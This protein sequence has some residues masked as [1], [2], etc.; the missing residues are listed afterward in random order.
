[1]AVTIDIGD[2]TDIHPRNKREVGRRLALLALAHTYGRTGFEWS[3]PR[4][5]A[6]VVQDDSVL[7]RFTH[8]AGLRARGGGDIRGFALAG[9]DRVFF[10][11]RAR[12][13]GD[14][15]VVVTSPSVRA[16]K[17]VRYAWADNP[18][19][20]LENSAGLPAAPFR[21]DQD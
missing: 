18:D 3:G 7:V 17:T 11:A 19:A 16:P 12:V 9:E 14:D 20:N 5:D 13:Q 15:A 4:R 1:M 21:S 6:V 8:A 10:A 2:P